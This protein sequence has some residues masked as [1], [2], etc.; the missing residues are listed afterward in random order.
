[1][2]IAGNQTVRAGCLLRG[3]D[4]PADHIATSDD[5]GVSKPDVASFEHVVRAARAEPDADEITTLP[6]SS[7]AELLERIFK[8][9][10]EVR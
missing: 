1:M 8:F 9:N 7:L 2:G 5:W 3:L 10:A 4:L 6:I